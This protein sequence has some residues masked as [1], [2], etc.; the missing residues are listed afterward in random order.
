MN[1][2]LKIL[3]IVFTIFI[4]FTAVLFLIVYLRSVN[5]QSILNEYNIDCFA[6]CRPESKCPMVKPYYKYSTKDIGFIINSYNLTKE[7][8]EKIKQKCN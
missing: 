8:F 5:K 7:K 6:G 1:K 3:V 4:V 2:N